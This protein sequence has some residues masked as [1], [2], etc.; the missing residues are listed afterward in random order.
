MT[1]FQIFGDIYQKKKNFIVAYVTF[2]LLFSILAFGNG[3][4]VFATESFT[5]AEILTTLGGSGGKM[6]AP[7]T[8]AQGCLSG[9]DAST[10]M[11]LL[12]ATSFA[13][14]FIPPS[15][16]ETLGN[17]LDIEGL[18]SLSTYSFGII[19]FTVFRIFCVVWF[20]VDKL[21]KSNGISQEVAKILGDFESLLTVVINVMVIGS[22]FLGNVQLGST[23]YAASLDSG[24]ME[25]ITNSKH[26]N[27]E[28]YHHKHAHIRT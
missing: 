9:I 24:N 1:Y 27:H 15:T 22:Q 12:C 20:I 3:N 11:F 25:V 28:K 21:S 19:D 5:N 4:T 26:N 16:L 17:A 18:E 7:L 23:A 14:D 8:A 6:L 2:C 13:L 10:T